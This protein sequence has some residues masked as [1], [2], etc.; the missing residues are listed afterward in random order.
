MESYRLTEVQVVNYAVNDAKKTSS[1]WSKYL[2]N[3]DRFLEY[4]L[5]ELAKLKE[6]W[7]RKDNAIK[8]V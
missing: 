7:A 1:N 5:N 4:N 2:T 3:L 8:T 6:F